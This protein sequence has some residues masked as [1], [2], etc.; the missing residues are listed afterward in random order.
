[1]TTA[2][3]K[4]V[5]EEGACALFKGAVPRMIVV[6]MYFGV[7]IYVCVCMRYTCALIYY[8][9]SKHMNDYVYYTKRQFYRIV[10]KLIFTFY[11]HKSSN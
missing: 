5:A 10:D 9:Y 3:R 8:D 7:R 2:L 1:M 6:G 11:A 4:I